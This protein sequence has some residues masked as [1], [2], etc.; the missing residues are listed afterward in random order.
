[1]DLPHQRWKK[2]LV[3]FLAFGK[4]QKHNPNKL[5]AYSTTPIISK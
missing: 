1:M 5:N 4:N 3:W 2:N